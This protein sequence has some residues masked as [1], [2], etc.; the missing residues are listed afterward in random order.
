M[1]IRLVSR[2]LLRRR[3]ESGTADRSIRMQQPEST[4]STLTV[5]PG[6]TASPT[7]L[8]ETPSDPG[9]ASATRITRARATTASGS[10][11][12]RAR[13][14][15]F[16]RYAAHV[17]WTGCLLR[18]MVAQL[19]GPEPDFPAVHGAGRFCHAWRRTRHRFRT[20]SIEFM[21]C[22]S[23][24]HSTSGWLSDEKQGTGIREQGP[25]NREL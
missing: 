18:A 14:V 9:P 19:L 24:R 10:T 16:A 13:G 6:L 3:G 23:R 25:E 15:V 4:S 22:V 2:K 17:H 5:G 7:P 1:Q 8:S 20:R 12:A 21:D 11:L